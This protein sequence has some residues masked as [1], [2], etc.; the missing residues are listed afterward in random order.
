M[1]LRRAQLGFIN[2]TKPQKKKKKRHGDKL[3]QNM[4]LLPFMENI[5]KARKSSGI[6]KQNI[7]IILCVWRVSHF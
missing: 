2:N 3:G 4:L 7:K 1:H 5:G 6:I